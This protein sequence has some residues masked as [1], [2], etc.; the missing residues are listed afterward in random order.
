MATHSSVL[1]W[2]IPGTGK[3]GGL[4]SMGSHRIRHNGS[5]LAAHTG[6]RPLGVSQVAQWVKDPPAMQESRNTGLIPG[7]E[8]SPGGGH[9]NP[10]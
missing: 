3:P 6:M 8:R 7:M 5:D 9:G 1:G 10:L 2:R 4:P